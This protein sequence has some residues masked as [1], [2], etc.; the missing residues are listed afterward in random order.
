MRLLLEEQKIEGISK[1]SDL[2]RDHTGLHS[3]V[4]PITPSLVML[5]ILYFRILG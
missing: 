5:I 4:Q 1:D 2:N 3:A